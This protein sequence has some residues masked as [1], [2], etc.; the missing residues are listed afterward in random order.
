MKIQAKE[1]LLTILGVIFTL[2]LTLLFGDKLNSPER[3]SFFDIFLLLIFVI[4]FIV[5][6]FYRKIGEVDEDIKKLDKEQK[7]LDERLKINEQLI[8]MKAD[9]KELQR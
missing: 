1:L 2:I 5:I 9:I 7:R 4:S 8:D 3:F 6:F